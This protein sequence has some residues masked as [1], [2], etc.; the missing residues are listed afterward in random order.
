M[1]CGVLLYVRRFHLDLKGA[2]YDSYV[3]PAML[4]GSEAW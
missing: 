2:V 4:Y 3:S 1:E